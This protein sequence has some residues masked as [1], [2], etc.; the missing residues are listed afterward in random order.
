MS[1]PGS[2]AGVVLAGIAGVV[3]AGAFLAAPALAV[4][5]DT[6]GLAATGGRAA[7]IEPGD[8]TTHRD[9]VVVTNRTGAPLA[10][11]LDVVGVTRAADGSYRYGAPGSGLAARVSVDA[12]DLQLGPHDQRVVAVTVTTPRLPGVAE[13][14]A[15]TAE[16]GTVG[17]GTLAV[18]PRLAVFVEVPA[19]PAGAVPRARPGRDRGPLAALAGALAAAVLTVLAALAARRRRSAEQPA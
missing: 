13:Y 9:A 5:T 7:L 2:G 18:R 11:T 6:F 19:A 1:R 15:I 16:A 12:R 10:V 4:Q 14:A 3:L 17:T 8:G